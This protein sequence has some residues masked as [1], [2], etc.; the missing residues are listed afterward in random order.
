[1]LKS[2][3][4]Y[5]SPIRALLGGMIGVIIFLIVLGLFGFLARSTSWAL[6]SEFVDFLSANATLV[7]FFSVLFVIGDIFAAFSFPF[8]LPFPLFSAAGS[9]LL[10]SFMIRIIAFI[11]TFTGMGIS[12][13]PDI[14][15]LILYP[16]TIVVVL[17][18]GYLSIASRSRE[19]RGDQAARSAS[20]T[21]SGTSTT[22][23]TWGEIGE[24]FRKVFT[25]LC[26]RIHEDVCRR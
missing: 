25:D 10:V 18:A 2:R 6:F 19:E 16:I 24:G 21:R 4:H 11:D 26:R 15:E 12:P 9:V 20:P 22:T 7:I 17:V 5:H 14:L 3:N 8:N 13:V 23:P 1:M